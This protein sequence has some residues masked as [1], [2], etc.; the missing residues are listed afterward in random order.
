[1]LVPSPTATH[2]LD[3]LWPNVYTC[4]I[5]ATLS[6]CA[7]ILFFVSVMGVVYIIDCL[8]DVKPVAGKLRF[9]VFLL[10]T[11]EL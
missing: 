7:L 11:N 9:I 8:I 4:L 10:V 6:I 1:M 3:I 5:L 2:R